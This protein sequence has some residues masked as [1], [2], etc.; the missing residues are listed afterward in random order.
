MANKYLTK[1]SQGY[2][3]THSRG[4]QKDASLAAAGALH[5]IQNLVT[6]G[7]LNSR[8]AGQRVAQSF[9]H[10]LAGVHEGSAQ[11]KAVSA[12]ASILSPEMESVYR[13]ANMLG[14]HVKG[15]WDKLHPRA[16]VILRKMTRGEIPNPDQA[17]KAARLTVQQQADMGQLIGKVKA[18][19]KSSKTFGG[20]SPEANTDRLQKA[21]ETVKAIPEENV[22]QLRSLFHSKDHP[23]L[24]N[25]VAEI[26]K[27][28]APPKV[29][30]PGPMRDYTPA[31]LNAGLAVADPYTA[32]ANLSKTLPIVKKIKQNKYV[33]RVLDKMDE[34]FITGPIKKSIEDPKL[35][36]GIGGDTLLQKAKNFG[37][38]YILNPMA[39]SAKNTA[40]T[41]AYLTKG[42]K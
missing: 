18:R 40:G 38:E 11:R 9:Q 13:E 28:Q 4:L 34:V 5:L 2:V 31:A 21:V 8:K 36:A 33:K 1:I 27:K 25:Y 20:G 37:S 26:G 30:V 17:A 24:K 39:H 3:D 6:K 23:L 29:P 42:K 10:G 35:D 12:A 7:A 22:D 19:L 15:D 41:I 32:A 16:K 14:H